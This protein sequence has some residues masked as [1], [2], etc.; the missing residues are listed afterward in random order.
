[1]WTATVSYCFSIYSEV[2]LWYNIYFLFP[3]QES[4]LYLLLM[5]IFKPLLT[6]MLCINV[7]DSKYEACIYLGFVVNIEMKLYSESILS[8]KLPLP[9]ACFFLPQWTDGEGWCFKLLPAGLCS[10]VSSPGLWV[11]ARQNA[12]TLP[13]PLPVACLCNRPSASPLASYCV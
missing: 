10:G 5:W 8:T 11:L 12:L 7:L 3:P 4:S 1:M 13:I 9:S 2:S 6:L